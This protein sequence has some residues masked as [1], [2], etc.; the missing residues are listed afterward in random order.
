MAEEKE[1]PLP[2]RLRKWSDAMYV[3][4]LIEEAAAALE[5]LREELEELK[6]QRR[7][8]LDNDITAR[9]MK[10]QEEEIMR[11]EAEH[12]AALADAKRLR[13]AL[14]LFMEWYDD[15]GYHPSLEF[16]AVD[17][18]RAA[19]AAKEAPNDPR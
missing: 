4:S 7:D 17:A 16:A 8:W 6:Q 2:E 15:D 19:L 18:A 1:A 5:A 10:S 12:D 14:L 3:G 11:L 13:E 9:T